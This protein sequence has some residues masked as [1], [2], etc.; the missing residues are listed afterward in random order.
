MENKS[1]EISYIYGLIDPRNDEIRYIG[2]TINSKT[3]LSGHITESKDIE[4]VNYRVKWIRKLISL[5]L[6]PKIIFLRTCSSH[7]YEK[8]ETEYIRIYSN[9]RLTNSDETGQGNINRKREVLDRQSENRGRKVYQYDL[10]GNFLKEFR[11]ARVAAKELNTNHGG[12]SRCC[13][14]EYKHTQGFIFKYEKNIIEKVENPN[15]IKKMVIELDIFDNI[16]NEWVSIME[17]SRSTG[18]DSSNI[19]RV[20]NDKLPHIK[21]RRFIFKPS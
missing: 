8:Y 15:S 13:N 7:E 3:R 17:C 12:I 6:K 18:I 4:V 14:G 5:G 9:N 2:K 20:C 16:I 10:D 1:C 11:S 21:K 19:S